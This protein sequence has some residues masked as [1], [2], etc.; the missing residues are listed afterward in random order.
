MEPLPLGIVI[1]LVVSTPIEAHSF[2]NRELRL[3]CN[4]TDIERFW[5]TTEPMWTHTTAKTTGNDFSCLVDIKIKENGSY[6]IF[7][8]SFYSYSETEKNT[9]ALKGLVSR[10]NDFDPPGMLL[11][12]KN[13]TEYAVENLLYES[14]DGKCG[15][16]KFFKHPDVLRFDLRVKNSS[17]EKE[18][19]LGCSTF[20]WATYKFHKMR[21]SLSHATVYNSSCQRILQPTLSTC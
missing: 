18:L 3:G 21:H 8:R 15:V 10:G 16:F 9:L 17:V 2:K 13:G 7:N 1:V 12:H 6:I 14:E 20:F 5:N 11:Y 4:N 19:D